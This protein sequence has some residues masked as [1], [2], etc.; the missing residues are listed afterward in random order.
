MKI[1]TIDEV[2][3]D[4]KDPVCKLIR[5][6][7]PDIVLNLALPYQDLTIMEAC[8]EENVHYLDTANYESKD[9]A[10]FEYKLQWDLH[11]YFVKRGLMA[12]LG[13]GFDPG[14][15]NIYTAYNKKHLFDTIDYL[16]IL[17]CNGGDH[18]QPFATN[19]NP[20]INIREITAKSKFY[21]NGQWVYGDPLSK[22][23]KFDFPEIGLK[24][25][26]LC[27]MKN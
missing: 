21:L 16:D 18:G 19:F 6:Y 26:I 17:D 8:I 13:C 1:F 25:C 3:A 15:T 4:Y 12:L 14:V 20:E 7:K 27:I 2:D 10:K 23:I 22:N 11:K 5:K 24:K 9:E